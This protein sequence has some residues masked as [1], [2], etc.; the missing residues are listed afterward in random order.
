MLGHVDVTH[1]QNIALSPL[2]T[3]LDMV[4]FEHL[5]TM[6]VIA[7]A[8]PNQTTVPGSNGGSDMVTPLQPATRRRKQIRLPPLCLELTQTLPGSYITKR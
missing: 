6:T 5:M 7:G 2:M 3:H 8:A 1:G 4:A